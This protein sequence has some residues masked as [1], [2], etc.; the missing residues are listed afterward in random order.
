[1]VRQAHHEKQCMKTLN[2][3]LSL[4]KDEAKDLCFFSSL[5][6]ETVRQSLCR[7]F[8]DSTNNR[9]RARLSRVETR[10]EGP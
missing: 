2:L 5:L 3:I 6:D 7:R 10:E 1:M 8:C 9:S 4:S